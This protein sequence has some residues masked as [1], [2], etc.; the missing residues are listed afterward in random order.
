MDGGDA[1]GT[2]VTNGRGNSRE[3]FVVRGKFET[4]DEGPCVVDEEVESIREELHC[5]DMGWGPAQN[6][7]FKWVPPKTGCSNF[8]SHSTAALLARASSM[9][10]TATIMKTPSGAREVIDLVASPSPS[11]NYPMFSSPPKS[12]RQLKKRRDYLGSANRTNDIIDLESDDASSDDTVPFPMSKT[13]GPISKTK[14]LSSPATKKKVNPK[15]PSP[16]SR[17]TLDSWIKPFGSVK[18]SSLHEDDDNND[19]DVKITGIK[20]GNG[21]RRS[22]SRMAKSRIDDDNDD[23]DVEIIIPSRRLSSSTMTSA[24]AATS[25]TKRFANDGD[26]NDWISRIRDVFPLVSRA[27]VEKLLNK[28]KSFTTDNDEEDAYHTVMTVLAECGDP[29][30]M[31]ISDASFAAITITIKS[32]SP[33][34]KRAGQRKVATL[35]CKCCYV[36]YEF[37]SMVSC[38]SGH[39][40][41]GTCLQKHTEQR[42][43]G[44]GNFGVKPTEGQQTSKALEILCMTSG[45]ASGFREGQLRKALSDKVMKKYDELQF[46][47]VIESAQMKDVFKCPKCHYIAVRDESLPPLLF[48]CPQCLFNSC[49]EC[50]EEFHPKILCDQVESKN[51]TDG[52]TKVEEAMTLAL[53][54]I[55]PKPLCKKKIL[56]NEGCN[57][58]TCACGTLLCYVCGKEIL[59]TVGYKHFCQT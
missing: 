51:E 33:G 3:I 7:V 25:T 55:C 18:R 28:A 13:K 59:S 37:E 48:N 24:A 4:V 22:R 53:V 42:V 17:G 15:T 49:T 57:K 34:K 43:F 30:G 39:L 11:N 41:C 36:E 56:K 26:I 31:T 38:R 12:R 29:T 20:A 40:F 19:D 58:M 6:R 47:A 35:E 27:K 1:C 5:C 14:G 52:R 8:N 54:R 32:T 23:D 10:T 46:A 44:I 9:S 45:C 50:G 16:A 21:K 2:Y